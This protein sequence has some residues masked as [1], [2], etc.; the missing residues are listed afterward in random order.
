MGYNGRSKPDQGTVAYFNA[1]RV[2]IFK[3]DIIANE[4]IAEYPDPSQPV[5]EWP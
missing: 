4:D 3:I 2:F 1:L 5:K